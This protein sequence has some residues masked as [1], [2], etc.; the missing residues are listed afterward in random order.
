MEVRGKITGKSLNAQEGTFQSLT[1]EQLIVNKDVMVTNNLKSKSV[2]AQAGIF[3]GLTVNFQNINNDLSVKGSISAKRVSLAVGTFPDY[4]FEPSYKLKPLEEVEAY[5]K[6]HHH[7]PNVPAA[8]KVI[9]GGLDVGQMNILLMEKVEELTLHAIA[10]NK[11]IKQL[12]KEVK[13]LKAAVK[14]KK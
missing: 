3:T 11:Q 2:N 9:K 1:A 14:S 13:T 8:Q 5:I 4:V 7:L 12:L 10:Q 6:K